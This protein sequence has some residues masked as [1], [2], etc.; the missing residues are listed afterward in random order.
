MSW[1]AETDANRLLMTLLV[2][3]QQEAEYR[4]H[5]KGLTKQEFFARYKQFNEMYA[6]IDGT[7]EMKTS[8]T[9]GSCRRCVLRH[10]S[11]Y[12]A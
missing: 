11:S 3:R 8:M 12:M 4:V 5:R 7:P 10:S 2:M 9:Q 1:L 6:Q